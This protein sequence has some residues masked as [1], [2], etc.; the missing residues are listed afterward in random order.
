MRAVVR[1]GSRLVFDDIAKVEPGP[2]QVLVR[3]LCCG[4]CGS[5]L[6]A[7]HNLDQIADLSKRAGLGVRDP[8]RDVVFGHEFCAEVL[9]YGPSGERR[10]APGTRWSRCRRCCAPTVSRRSASRTFF[11]VVTRSEWC[12]RRR[13]PARHYGGHD[14]RPAARH[15]DGG[16]RRYGR[17]LRQPDRP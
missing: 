1:R 11:P 16:A 15:R 4:I 10:F 3:T 7:L 2:G 5:D 6:Q 9:D 14:R 8:A 17:R 12:S 13:D